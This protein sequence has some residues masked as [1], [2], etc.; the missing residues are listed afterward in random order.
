MDRFSSHLL[1]SCAL[2]HF[3]SPRHVYGR[4]L[5]NQRHE[6]KNLYGQKTGDEEVQRIQEQQENNEATYPTVRIAVAEPDL[7]PSLKTAYIL[8]E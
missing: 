3:D 7:E 6:E 5:E 2:V 1:A 4:W 8:H